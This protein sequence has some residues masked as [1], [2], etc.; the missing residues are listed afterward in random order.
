MK[1]TFWGTSHGV[2]AADRFCTATLIQC[3]D[4]AYLIDGGAPVADLMIRNAIP[5]SQ[6]KAVFVT[7]MHS[8]HTFGI[9]HLCSLA[10]WYFKEAS[11]D[12]YLPEQG[13]V[14]AFRTLLLA[15]DKMLDDTRIRLKTTA[16]GL[17]YDDGC[18]AVTAIPTGHMGKE[19]LSYAY[20]MEGEGKRVVF[21]GDLRADVTDFPMVVE[22][23]P[24]EAVVCEMAHFG[25]EQIQPHLERCLT[26]QF[27][28]HHIYGM[29]AA[30][31]AEVK[32]QETLSF[33]VHFVED[34]DV[35]EV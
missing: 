16:P 19:Y 17:L 8:D 5:Y 26:K 35:W 23:V 32:W 25:P 4:R 1:L 14:E 29:E 31:A 3:D 2:P 6:L 30:L 15:G 28:F 10:N 21:T 22:T 9:P 12:V 27:F 24:T 34:G 13:G 11:F 18:L 33:P 20:L 7:H